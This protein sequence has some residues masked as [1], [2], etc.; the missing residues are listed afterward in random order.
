MV[1]IFNK[2]IILP[3]LYNFWF[4]EKQ[5]VIHNYIIIID[6]EFTNL[7]KNKLASTISLC[8]MIISLIK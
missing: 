8:P 4:L 7:G 5:H 1:H 6:F 2:H 3:I